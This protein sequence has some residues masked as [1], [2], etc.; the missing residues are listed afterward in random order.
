MNDIYVKE[1]LRP[2]EWITLRGNNA[3]TATA[4]AAG[5]MAAAPREAAAID[6]GRY[7]TLLRLSGGDGA[8]VA[9]GAELA[10][11]DTAEMLDRVWNRSGHWFDLC[12][13]GGKVLFHPSQ[14]QRPVHVYEDRP[15]LQ[16]IE[17][18]EEAYD[19]RT[20]ESES[21][22]RLWD[23]SSGEQKL[24]FE[25]KFPFYI[26]R[27]QVLAADMTGNGVKDIVVT[28]WDGTVVYSREGQFLYSLTQKTAKGW[29]MC[30]KRGYVGAYDIDHD[31]LNE[32]M[33]IGTLQNHVDMLQNSGRELSVGW[34]HMFETDTGLGRRLTN[35]PYTVVGDFDGD[36]DMEFMINLWNFY[37]DHQWHVTCYNAATGDVKYDRPGSFCYLAEDIDGDGKPEIFCTR[38][39]D[40]AVPDFGEQEILAFRDGRVSV[41]FS[42]RGSWN[43]ARWRTT[44]DNVVTHHESA[45]GCMGET[46]PITARINGQKN[47]FLIRE[48]DRIQTITGYAFA[49][50]AAAPSGFSVQLPA[51]TTGLIERIEPGS[52]DGT[53]GTGGDLL[54]V[55]Q[56]GPAPFGTVECQGA[57][58]TV[59]AYHRKR[60]GIVALPV[61]ADIDN[62]GRNEIIIANQRGEIECFT[63]DSQGRKVPRWSRPGSG[64]AW[65]Y[66]QTLDYGVAVDDLDG[67]GFREILIRAVGDKG[68][69][70][71]AV[72]DKDGN[73]V[74]QREFLDVHG[75]ELNSFKGNMAFF[76][77][78]DLGRGQR[79]IA[80]TVQRGIGTNGRTYLLDGRTGEIL[81]EK[82]TARELFD[83]DGTGKNTWIVETGAGGFLLSAANLGN[84][85][86]TIAAGYGGLVWAMD[87]LTRRILFEKFMTGLFWHLRKPENNGF[88]VQCLVPLAVKKPDGQLCLF[89]FERSQCRRSARPG[90]HPGLAPGACRFIEPQLAVLV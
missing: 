38:A 87:G 54:L 64:M 25:V 49:G 29:H 16:V 72:L 24:L 34:F 20:A 40:L 57:A 8:A 76:G 44:P 48:Q 46:R 35:V 31:G 21:G 90:R 5:N 32:L 89:L 65:Q 7:E 50:G 85:H 84:G 14:N 42:G 88:W 1:I 70:A 10:G 67:D 86:D 59:L 51:G 47:F 55:V 79:D 77:T 78:A 43:K 62:D 73:L 45:A 6:L 15:G 71:L 4:T 12:G 41:V 81:E 53:G 13:T 26:E 83:P 61:V 19:L 39:E 23:Y 56:S 80:M 3:R 52:A 68:S 75:G 66:F 11:P 9:L 18:F 36:G 22:M 60:H 69:A 17:A 33:I 2:G 58:A 28:G 74:W 27:P 82:A 37:D 30:R 63:L